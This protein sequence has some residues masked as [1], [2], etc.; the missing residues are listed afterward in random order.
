MAPAERPDSAATRPAPAATRPALAAAR[1]ALAATRPAP[2]GVPRNSGPARAASTARTAPAGPRRLGPFTPAQWVGVA[3]ILALAIV[4][5]VTIVVLAVRWFLGLDFMR[6]F[7][8]TFPGQYALP[9][10]A[11]VGFPAWVGWQHFFNVF[12]ILLIIRTGLTVRRDKRPGAFWTSKRNRKHKISLTLW[13]HQG[14]DVL[15]LVNGAIF[16]VLL[17]STGQWMRLV[18]T[19]W[20]VFPNAVTAA[21]KYASLDWPTDDGWVN[22][23]SLQQLAY[24]V[25]VF[26]AAPL[27]AITGVRMSGVWPKSA[28]RLNSAYPVE[29]ARAVHFPVMIFFVAFIIVH[30]TLVFATGALR[31]LNHMYGGQDAVNWVGFWIF[32]L[33]L[34][35]M[36]AGWVAARP[37]IVAPIARI[38][39]KVTAR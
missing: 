38:F 14:L 4:G 3:V 21:L 2:V 12:L 39:G 9:D 26:I 13:L 32:V 28:K 29:W 37:L 24:F 15:W 20:S 18:P 35:V 5:L 17:F 33:S 25:V 8:H 19:D 31:N 7:V 23:N 30:V 1:P 34:V 11:P 27:A 22:F 16:V 36:A 10:S 6:D